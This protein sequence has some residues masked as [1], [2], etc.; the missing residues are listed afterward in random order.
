MERRGNPILAAGGYLRFSVLP[1]KSKVEGWKS[2]VDQLEMGGTNYGNTSRKNLLPSA[3]PITYCIF[4]NF[5][6]L[7]VNLLYNQ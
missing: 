2:K 1:D 4:N 3:F 5:P 6:A 7:D